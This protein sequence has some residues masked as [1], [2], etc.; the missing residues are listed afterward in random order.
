MTSPLQVTGR[1]LGLSAT[2]TLVAILLLGG[3]IAACGGSK[4]SHTASSHTTGAHAAT[5]GPPA[6]TQIK[7]DWTAFFAAST[8]TARREALLQNGHRFAAVLAAQS[9]SPLAA[10]SQA[11]VSKVTLTGPATARVTY[12]VLLAGKPALTHQTGTASRSAGVW[13]VSDTSFCS[14]L[15]LEG[16]TPPAC[17]G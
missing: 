9:K 13:Q 17:K 10:E 6:M 16:A 1:G 3:L 5:P 8:P 7:Q 12:D 15:E 11:K 4:S 2:S 14:L